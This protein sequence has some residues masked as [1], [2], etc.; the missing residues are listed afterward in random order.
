MNAIAALRKAS[1]FQVLEVVDQ[2]FIAMHKLSRFLDREA[3]GVLL[4]KLALVEV[5][6]CNSGMFQ[7][8]WPWFLI[9]EST[10]DWLLIDE[11][12]TIQKL[13]LGD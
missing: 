11:V 12:K 4:T 2:I 1:A 9:V 6:G 3:I 8:R 10:P 13:F 7:N 5:N